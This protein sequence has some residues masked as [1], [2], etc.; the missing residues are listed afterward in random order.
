[1]WP[2]RLPAHCRVRG[3]C[4]FPR[5][6]AGAEVADLPWRLARIYGLKATFAK[7]WTTGNSRLNSLTSSG[8]SYA[9]RM[10]AAAAW[11]G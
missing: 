3:L 7:C 11:F 1:M 5:D 6:T 4:T 2:W 8:V 9:E 10:E